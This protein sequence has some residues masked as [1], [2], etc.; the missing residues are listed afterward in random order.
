[1]SGQSPN[2]KFTDYEQPVP[3]RFNGDKAHLIVQFGEPFCNRGVY[4]VERNCYGF[5]YK[6]IAA[7]TFLWSNAAR[8]SSAL[9]CRYGQS[10]PWLRA[11]RL[12]YWS[13]Q[14]RVRAL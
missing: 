13:L 6:H 10:L 14:R 11:Y 2:A 9:S 4:N 8:I 12:A 5:T 7:I 3:E 1:M